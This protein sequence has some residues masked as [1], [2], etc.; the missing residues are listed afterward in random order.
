MCTL[1]R[2]AAGAILLALPARPQSGSSVRQFPISGE[3]ETYGLT[4][5][6]TRPELFTSGAIDVEVRDASGV[7]ITK[8][9]HPFDLDLSANLKPRAP[10]P[11]TVTF[12]A[13]GV[14]VEQVRAQAHL[15]PLHLS[16]GGSAV[17]AALPNRT[18]QQA[19][20]IELGQTVFGS[21]DERPYVPSSTKNAYA[22]LVKGF[23]WFRFTVPGTEPKLA[24]FVLETPD[25]DV[26]PDLDVFEP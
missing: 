23:Q 10:G 16:S 6:V 17:V 14:S 1:V 26:P 21:S 22:D 3:R 24:H 5:S 9:L 19:Q 7:L 12:K 13:K 18:W 20:V 25:R 11:I 4:V 8:T 2:I 15:V